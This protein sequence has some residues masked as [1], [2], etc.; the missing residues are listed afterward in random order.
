MISLIHPSR[1]RPRKSF[2]TINKWHRYHNLPYELIVSID[3]DDPQRLEYAKL[4]WDYQGAI[5]LQGKNLSAVDAINNGARAAT[6]DILI[7]VSDDTEC[8]EVGIS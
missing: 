1:G 6:G 7:V 5:I 2:E 8:P 4:F 3:V